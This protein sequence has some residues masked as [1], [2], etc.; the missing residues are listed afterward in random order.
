MR[1]AAQVEQVKRTMG[2]DTSSVMDITEA[3]ANGTA[4]RLAD[5][6][7]KGKTILPGDSRPQHGRI[8][9][10]AAARRPVERRLDYRGHPS[11]SE[12]AVDVN[13]GSPAHLL[14]ASW[15]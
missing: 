2:L 8:A 6:P 11:A 7:S 4:K 10:S 1:A 13:L 15:T 12:K 3:S 9:E 5:D 14:S